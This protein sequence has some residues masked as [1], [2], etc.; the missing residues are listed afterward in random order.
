MKMRNNYFLHGSKMDVQ[1]FLHRVEKVSFR[2][3]DNIK[4]F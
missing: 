4:K 2:K 1:V 3:V